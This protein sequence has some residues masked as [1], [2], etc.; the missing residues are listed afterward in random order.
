MV[1]LLWNYSRLRAGLCRKDEK[2]LHWGWG[3][4]SSGPRPWVQSSVPH[5]EG[6]KKGMREREVEGGRERGGERRE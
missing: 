3:F 6:R 2:Y 5:M 4:G 1:F